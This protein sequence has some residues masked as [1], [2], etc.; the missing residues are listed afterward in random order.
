MGVPLITLL[1]SF[2]PDI[3]Q[4]GPAP[5]A[6]VKRGEVALGYDV[7]F[8]FSEV[9]ADVC[10]FVEDST[11][12]WGFSK[13]KTNTYHV[14]Q[15]VVTKGIGHDSWN[16]DKAE[17]ITNLYK[18]EEGSAAERLSVYNAMRGVDR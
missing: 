6:A 10:H 7:G 15:L 14:G 13:T 18:H 16:S 3:Y 11:S 4:C 5:I 1:I 2:R 12:S 9:N 8:V 17:N